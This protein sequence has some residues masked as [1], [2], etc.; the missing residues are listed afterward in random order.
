MGA[1][2][3][4]GLFVGVGA[5]AVG[6]LYFYALSLSIVVVL[7]KDMPWYVVVAAWLFLFGVLYYEKSLDR[8]LKSGVI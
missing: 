4:K 2:L 8:K 1:S 3:V 6:L 5:F 7:K